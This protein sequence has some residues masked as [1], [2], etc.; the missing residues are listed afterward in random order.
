MFQYRCKDGEDPT[1]KD[2]YLQCLESMYLGWQIG[3]HNPFSFKIICK[4]QKI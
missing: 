1:L 4:H 3:V 2:R